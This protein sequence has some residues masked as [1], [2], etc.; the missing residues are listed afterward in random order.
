[1]K[2]S[3]IR[4]SVHDISRISLRF[5]RATELWRMTAEPESRIAYSS[6]SRLEELPPQ[7]GRLALTDRGIDLGD[8]MTG[9]R[10]EEPHAGLHRAALGIGRAVVQPPYPRKRDRGCAHRARLQG[11]VEVAMDQPL[12]ARDPGG[13]PDRE[14]FGMRGRIAASQGAA[15]GRGDELVVK[16]DAASDP[17]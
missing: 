13:L 6:P 16:H 17:H 4:D 12:A 1:M 11:D 8:V 10:R 5:I 9:R 14:D 2:R 15:S 7:R 3:V